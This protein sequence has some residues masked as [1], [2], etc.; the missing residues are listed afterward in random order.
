MAACLEKNQIAHT[1]L[2]ARQDQAEAEIVANAGAVGS[3]TVATNMAGRGTDI[4]LGPGAAE[5]GG[6]HVIS[7][8]HNN[9]R[10]IDRQLIG[11]CARQGDP[12]SAQIFLCFEQPLLRRTIPA[13][14]RGVLSRTEG[15]SR[16]QWLIKLIARVPQILE[17]GRQR[18]QRRNLLRQDLNLDQKL[19]NISGLD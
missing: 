9:S 11:R 14:L 1:V 7:C 13:W 2:N 19:T 17:E 5:L 8:Q 18:M 12:G 3:V 10:R 16:P 6:L 15:A 4:P